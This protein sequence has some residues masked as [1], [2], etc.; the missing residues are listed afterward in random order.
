MEFGW[1]LPKRKQYLKSL[2]DEPSQRTYMVPLFGYLP[3]YKVPLELPLYRLENGRTTGLQAEY[4]AS[5][6]GTPADFFRLDSEVDTAQR[7]QHSLL[8]KLARGPKNLF[9]EFE[10]SPQAE[11]IILSANGYVVNGNRRLSTW[12]ELFEF[13]AKKYKHFHSVDAVVLP[14]TDEKTLDRLEAELQ[15]KED[16]KADYRWTALG[17][18]LTE[19]M[20]RF[21][22][23][24]E[25]VAAIYEMGKKDIRELFDCLAYGE[26]YLES[27]GT[28]RRF[29]DLDDKEYAFRQI[30]RT[31]PK[32]KASESDKELFEKA[33][34][35][36]T[37]EAEEGKR[38]YAEIPKIAD[39]LEPVRTN[40]IAELGIATDGLS[41]E[42]L[43]MKLVEALG[44]EDNFETA[45]LSIRDTIEAETLKKKS[46]RKQD[47]VVS[48]IEKA[49]VMLR[50]AL[51]S[52]DENSTRRGAKVA[53]STIE[54]VVEKLQEWA[55]GDD[56]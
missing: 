8:V 50:D 25:Q 52:V 1:P 35:C 47:F 29:S 34:F 39:H 48:Q 38:I 15:L 7:A 30:C 44:D 11:P 9:S 43:S 40:L 12:R 55:E 37:D 13:D 56:Q 18:M 32:L 45:R 41:A 4:I 6:S 5:T 26:E 16:L 19:K 36:L 46:K 49:A 17:L 33:A 3:I 28:P 42:S 20:T 23:D 27:R 31:R 53:L 2:A 54:E 14:H 10:K 51:D 22:Y 21:H 24:I